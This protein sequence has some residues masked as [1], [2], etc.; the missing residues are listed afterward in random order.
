[1][2]HHDPSQSG[3]GIAPRYAEAQARA[4]VDAM[5]AAESAVL[6]GYPAD[7]ALARFFRER[8]HLGS[9]DRRMINDGIFAAFRWRG[10]VGAMADRGPRVL[11]ESAVI[12]NAGPLTAALCSL[13]QAHHLALGEAAVPADE[14]KNDPVSLVKA[15]AQRA[16]RILGHPCAIESLL[17]DWF[18]SRIRSSESSER[19]EQDWLSRFIAWSRL[20]P[21]LWL[22]VLGITA[23]DAAR[24]I[25][26]HG[27][28]ADPSS[29][30]PGAVRVKGAPP[31]PDLIKAAKLRA[32]VQDLASQRIL[33][34]CQARPGERWWDACAGGGGKTL[35]LLD[36]VGTSGEICATDVRP[37]SLAELTVRA[38]A[39]RLPVPRTETLDASRSS[40]ACGP[41][42]GVLVDAPCSGSGT[43]ARN[44]DAPW[45]LTP[46]TLDERLD[47]QRRILHHAA[48]SVRAGGRLVYAT[49]AMGRPENDEQSAWFIREHP[50]FVL[51]ASATLWPW[52]GPQNGSYY[53]VFIRQ[54]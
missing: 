21:P 19:Q 47:A 23:A 13:A 12:Q 41:F 7:E 48:R 3:P 33:A 1:M 32:F 52:D 20:R 40:P 49:C 2:T 15:A 14:N 29:M 43:W 17:P 50:D 18:V 8:R 36:A 45:R 26:N 35:G 10:W 51:E 39:L 30:M 44:P 37:S 46:E 34:S 53:S 38:R 5:T 28:D 11:V 42:D 25:Q 24:R 22:R 4:L 16:E 6:R 31:L 9:R 27:W 54:R